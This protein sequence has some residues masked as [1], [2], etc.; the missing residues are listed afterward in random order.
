MNAGTVSA[1]A[2]PST[3]DS[4]LARTAKGAGWVIGWRM[5]TRI[6][7]LVS[8]LFLVRLLLPADFGLVTLAMS[9]AQAIDQLSSL[10]VEEAVIRERQPTRELYDS[11][12][13]INVIRGICTTAIVAAAS[14]PVAR[15]FGDMRLFPVMLVIAAGSLV[16]SFENIGIVDFRREIAFEKEFVLMSVPRLI[17]IVTAIGLAFLFRSYWALVCAIFSSIV[18]RVAMGY[19]MHPYRPWFRLR[20]WRQI[21]GFSFW[22]W[23]LS[24]S[25]LLRD[26]CDSFVI[27]RVF[28]ITQVGVFSLGTEIASL[29]TTELVSPLSRA[30]FSG[31]ASARG[32]D[33]STAEAGRAFLRVVGS[34][35]LI[36]LPAGV[37]I[38]LVADPIVKLAF[39]AH[40]TGATG[41]IR[42][43][44]VALT[45]TILGLISNALMNAHA[46]LRTMFR[47]QIAAVAVKL[48][49]LVVLVM[50]FGLVGAAVAVGLAAM[51]EHLLYLSITLRFLGL[52]AA[53]ILRCA[54]R[55]VA[56][57]L[58]MATGLFWLGLGWN[59]VPYDTVAIVGDLLRAV[60]IGAALYGT[61]VGACWLAAGRPDGAERD[62]AGMARQAS[63][64]IFR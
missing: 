32:S 34:T 2:M 46:L 63:G 52:G 12:F 37:G 7:G 4:I 1:E 41:V 62:M 50:R 38:S 31:F 47:I 43:L 16:S 24:L 44:G 49:L 6:L 21:A 54:W 5:V 11:A 42:V 58:A 28:N 51:L 36:A 26:R 60:P 55:S 8:T 27:G 61:A 64:R 17:S 57:T 25:T 10:G 48:V 45:V 3:G 35:T 15:F 19:A 56:G 22:S 9:F 13:T 14:W 29:P 23:L 39:G 20:A 53:D 40:W 59:A 18:I 30:C 33:G